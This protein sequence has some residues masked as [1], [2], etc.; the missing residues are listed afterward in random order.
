ML[1]IDVRVAVGMQTATYWSMGEAGAGGR[2]PGGS[3]GRDL[4]QIPS[5][6]V[7]RRSRA[8]SL[9]TWQTGVCCLDDCVPAPRCVP[10]FCTHVR[11]GDLQAHF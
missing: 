10:T 3:L 7:A 5:W 4:G 6:C 9:E 1:R 2:G 11:P 8:Q